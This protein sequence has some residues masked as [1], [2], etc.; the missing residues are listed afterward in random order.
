LTQKELERE[1]TEV[2]PKAHVIEKLKP[3]APK[4]SELKI[5]ISTETEVHLKRLQETYSQKKKRFVSVAEVIAFMTEEALEKHAPE[6]KLERERPA[7]PISSRKFSK[8]KP[9][10]PKRV[11]VPQRTKLQKLNEAQ[12]Q[13]S[14]TSADGRRC[15]ERLWLELHHKKPVSL[16]GG[17]E[18]ENLIY[19]CSSHHRNLHQERQH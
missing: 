12:N 11:P 17:N 14:Y 1:V 4:L 16:G 9:L 15:Q 6:K 19:L 3:V 13:C 7:K 18:K 5:G 2:N 8:D 10:L